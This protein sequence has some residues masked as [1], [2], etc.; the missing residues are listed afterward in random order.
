[1]LGSGLETGRRYD[2]V[3]K[4]MALSVSAMLGWK[5]LLLRWKRRRVKLGD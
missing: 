5:I 1:M 3:T 4:R 2:G